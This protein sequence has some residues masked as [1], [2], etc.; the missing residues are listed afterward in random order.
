MVP[1]GG[2]GLAQGELEHV[3][4]DGSESD[5]SHHKVEEDFPD[6]VIPL[7]ADQHPDDA[8]FGEGQRPRVRRLADE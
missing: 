1:D 5:E 3:H 7:D 8:E 2:Q 6:F 4:G